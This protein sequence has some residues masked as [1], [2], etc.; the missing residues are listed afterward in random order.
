M[1]RNSVE[2]FL[3]FL[4]IGVVAGVLEDLIAVKL[5]TGATIDAQVIWVVFLIAIP[6]AALS[7]LVVDREEIRPF[8]EVA[9]RIHRV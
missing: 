4:V 2:R 3:E 1:D 9:D 7:E 5:A 8:Q 6:F